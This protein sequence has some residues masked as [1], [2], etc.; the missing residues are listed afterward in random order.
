MPISL[1]L[2]AAFPLNCKSGESLKHIYKAVILSSIFATDSA[3]AA[4]VIANWTNSTTGSLAGV[5]FTTSGFGG[6][7]LGLISRSYLGPNFSGGPFFTAQALQYSATDNWT[8]TFAS[9][10]SNL[11]VYV[12]VWRGDYNTGINDGVSLYAFNRPFAI[13]SG[14]TGA[15]ITGNTLQL[16]DAGDFTFY[17]GIISFTGPVTSL[18]VSATAFN[19]SGQILTFATNTTTPEPSSVGLVLV[20]FIIGGSV[21]RRRKRLGFAR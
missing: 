4:P 19:N 18:S 12:D 9:P 20:C 8:I 5:N 10:L 7:F 16:P 2:S 14:M 6:P 21:N 3:L 17:N 1:R 15:S 11:Q 13:L